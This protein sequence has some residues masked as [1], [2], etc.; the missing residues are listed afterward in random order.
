MVD[1]MLSTIGSAVVNRGYVAAIVDLVHHA[2]VLR[3]G[4]IRQRSVVALPQVDVVR[5]HQAFDG[6]G[7]VLRL[8]VSELALLRSHLD[9]EQ[10]VVDL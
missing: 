10:V 3:R 5:A 9:V 2:V 4:R 7:K 6:V 8:E 1:L